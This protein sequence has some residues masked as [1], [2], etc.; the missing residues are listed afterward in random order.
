M[1]RILLPLAPLAL[2]L[3]VACGGSKTTSSAVVQAPATSLSYVDP[4]AAASE[5]KLVKDA[6]STSTHLVLNLVGPSDGSKYRGV[7]FTL[8]ADP[9]K[10]KFAQFTDKDGKLTGYYADGGVLLDK[11]SK[12][13]NCATFL[14]AG[15]VR[16]GKLM[17]G[18]FQ[19]TDEAVFGPTEGAAAKS[20]NKVVL[21]VAVDL[22]KNLNALPGPVPLAVL[23]ARVIGEHIDTMSTRKLMDVKLNV[24]TLELK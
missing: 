3:T 21:Q 8:Q 13:D 6:T 12:G 9:N 16:D 5:W 10:V 18:I 17:V 19:R 23:K 15:G 7:G 14:Q 1:K 24:G 20:C 22:D 4:T 11:D 2:L